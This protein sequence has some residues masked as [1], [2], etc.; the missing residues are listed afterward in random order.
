[1]VINKSQII[2]LDTNILSD[3]G[4]FEEKEIR[5]IV[6][7]L[8]VD[9]KLLVAVTPF[10]IL[11]VE[12]LP[13]ETVKLRI[14]YFLNLVNA[15]FLKGMDVLF[16]DEIKSYTHKVP[17]KSMLFITTFIS[18][19]KDGK[20]FNYLSVLDNLLADRKYQQALEEH[21][22]ILKKQQN[23]YQN[24]LLITSDQFADILFKENL[25]KS[26][27]TLLTGNVEDIAK[28]CPSYVAYIYSLYDKVGSKG[29]RKKAGEMNDTAMSYIFPYVGLVVTEKMQSNIFNNVKEANKIPALND[30]IFLK[31]SDVF[32]DGKFIL[33]EILSN[34]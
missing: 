10:N 19:S 28:K 21:Y 2:F 13:D 34:Y 14:K 30:T 24:K 12:K 22:A 9:L 1:M 32:V 26:H 15:I 5:D 16:E 33:K 27:P 31:H 8:S 17:I 20:P 6:F 11:E 25:V 23:H 7:Q 4:R 18:K 3:I 29:L